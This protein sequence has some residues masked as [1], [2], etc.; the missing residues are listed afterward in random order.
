M[1]EP[2]IAD[3]LQKARE[4]ITPREMWSPEGWGERG[5]SM[6]A[7]HAISR[8][9]CLDTYLGATNALGL[10]MGV[11]VVTVGHWN[12]S[13]SH[14]EVLAAFDRA[15]AVERMKEAASGAQAPSEA[16]A[17]VRA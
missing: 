2:S 7:A 15:I 9:A 11:D 16:R 13:H 14:K 6:C 10:A 3:V 8:V 4:L 12:D 5:G 1:S 17:T